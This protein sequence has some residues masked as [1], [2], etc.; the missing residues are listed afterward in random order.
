MRAPNVTARRTC[1]PVGYR[2]PAVVENAK[3]IPT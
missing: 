3:E 2:Q 1:V